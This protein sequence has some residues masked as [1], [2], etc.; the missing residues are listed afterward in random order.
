MS[1]PKI[2]VLFYSTYGT[3]HA[4]A[5]AAAAAATA[6]GAE[7]KLRRV[8]ETAPEAVVNS[9][10]AWKAQA[11]KHS[12]LPVA[13]PDDMVWADGYIFSCPT[14]FGQAASQMR[15]FIDTLGGVWSQGKLANKPIT[16][17]TSAQNPHGGQEAT[18]LGLYTTFM[19]WGAVIVTPGYTEQAFFDAG[20]NPYGTSVTQGKFDE[21]KQ[22]AVAA[23][24]QRLV[25]FATKLMG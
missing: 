10:D 16:A 22:K 7:V 3:N 17:M 20:G 18:I 19:H 24:A 5:E 15:A 14:R 1:K 25:R 9:Q 2:A 11:E 8:P 21:A 4:M 12:H 13:T 6:A 23:Q